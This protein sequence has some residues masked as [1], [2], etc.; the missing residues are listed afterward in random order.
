MTASVIFFPKK[1]SAVSFILTKTIEDISSGE[2]TLVSFLNSTCILGFPPSLITWKGQCFISA[3]TVWS[4]NFLPIKRLASNTVLFG[5][6]AT[7]F[8]A[9]SPINLSVSVN[10]T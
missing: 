8:L 1:A 4:S 10:A 9:A 5:F 6:I 3:W 2:K 7:W